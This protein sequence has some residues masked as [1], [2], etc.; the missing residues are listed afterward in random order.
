MHQLQPVLTAPAH[1]TARD[2]PCNFKGKKSYYSIKTRYIYY[3][4]SDFTAEGG[5][6]N[7]ARGTHFL[8]TAEGG[9]S[10]DMER[11]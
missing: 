8:E 1:H 6:S 7:W 10:Q 11:K 2:G 5:T 9:T 3:C 4:M